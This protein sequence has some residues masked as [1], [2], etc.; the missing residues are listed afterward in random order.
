MKRPRVI[1]LVLKADR[2]GKAKVARDRREHVTVERIRAQVSRDC[3][4]RDCEKFG[5]IVPGTYYA[6]LTSPFRWTRMGARRVPITEH[7]H[8]SCLPPEAVKLRRFFDGTP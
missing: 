7:Y 2:Y 5:I 8:F 3:D 1:R 4:N 6:A